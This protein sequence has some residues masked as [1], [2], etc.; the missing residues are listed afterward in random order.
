MP[1]PHTIR[2]GESIT[3]LAE[4]YG[5]FVETIWNHADNADLR[6]RRTDMDILM[7]GDVVVIPDKRLKEVSKSDKQKHVFRR[8][9]V[10]AKFRMQLF[11]FD[12]PRANQDYTLSIDGKLRNGTT[13]DQGVLEEHVPTGARE[14]ILI[15]GEDNFRIKVLFGELNPVDDI[16]GVKQR[17]RNLGYDPGPIDESESPVFKSTLAAFQRRVELEPT[18]EL[19]DP[20]RSKLKDLHESQGDLPALSADDNQS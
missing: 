5:H 20:T 17:L 12:T 4:R 15:I 6:Q 13:D 16:T 19:D 10:P 2:Q 14:G 7:P 3:S 9:G 11:D 8:R 18:G 1:T